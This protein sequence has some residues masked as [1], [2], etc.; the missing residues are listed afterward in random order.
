MSV[1]SASK[2]STADV[3]YPRDAVWAVLTDASQ[4]AKLTPMV[5]SIEDHG[6]TWLWKLAPIEVLGK[7]IGV[8]F[9]E[10][11][12]F[13]PRERI[14]Y[15]HAPRGQ[16]RAGVE[17][18]YV[19]ADRGDGTRLSIELRV[20]VDLPFPRLAK[21]AVQASMQAVIAAMGAG[22]ARNLERRLKAGHN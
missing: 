21:P 17:G 6:E 3:A 14:T 18:V 1:F 12:D 4:V 8:A 16:E 10:R 19:L 15:T 11:M 20:D 2:R 22:F 5:R 13:T 9:T 7:S